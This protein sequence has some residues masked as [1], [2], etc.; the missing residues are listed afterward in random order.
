[1]ARK[2]FRTPESDALPPVDLY[3][4]IGGSAKCRELSAAFYARVDNDPTL[5]PLFPGKTHKC[6]IEE[7]SAFLAQF[8]GGP[9]KDAQRRWWLSLRESHLRFSIG[10]KE[11]KV[12][13]E[14]MAKTLSDMEMSQTMRS[15]LMELF[16]ES[17]AYLVNTGPAVAATTCQPE[18]SDVHT[19]I[20]HRWE[21]Q[22]ELDKAVLAVREGDL[23]RV[24]ALIEGPLLPSWLQQSRSV[25]TQFVGVLIGSGHDVMAEYAL[26]TLWENPDLAHERYSGRTLLHAA[27]AAGNLPMVAHLLDLGVDADVQDER[28]HTPLHSAGNECG[29]SGAVVRALVHGGAS[30]D[31]CDGVKRCTALHMAA[32]RGNVEVAKA[33]VEFAANIE[34]RDSLGETPLR[35]A[36]NCGKT[37]VAAYL[38]ARGADPLSVGSKGLTP[39]S[40]ARSDQMR[41]LLQT[42]IRK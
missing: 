7:M 34:A 16:E 42:G 18:T 32:R 39:L 35:R 14:M 13:V 19:Q 25:F 38:L 4:A 37:A 41:R 6:A 24:T 21:Q 31:A 17:S 27:A 8:L 15:A 40:A 20:R 5:A 29:G 2:P 12:W 23:N 28:G 11:R 30:V 26:Q 36:V 33:L 22:C 9:S 1:M 10:Q 3:E